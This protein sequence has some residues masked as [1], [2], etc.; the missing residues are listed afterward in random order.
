MSVL[1][2]TTNTIAGIHTFTTLGNG[3]MG[4]LSNLNTRS[5]HSLVRYQQSNVSIT[6]F[7]NVSENITVSKTLFASNIQVLGDYVTLNTIT[8]NTEQM[9]IEN[10]G[11]G[12][13][14]K[15]TQTGNNSIAEFYDKESG[16]ALY[17]GNNGN[18]GIGTNMPLT[19]LHIVGNLLINGYIFP[20]YKVHDGIVYDPSVCDGTSS[21]RAGIS[22]LQLYLDGYGT[23]SGMKYLKCN[24]FTIQQIYCDFDTPNG[25]WTVPIYNLGAYNISTL[26]L[27]KIFFV[28][29]GIPNAGR[30][31]G[32][33]KDAWMSVKRTITAINDP[34]YAY[35]GSRNGG[36]ILTMPFYRPQVTVNSYIYDWVEVCSGN[37]LREIPNNVVGDQMDQGGTQI[38]G[39][40]WSWNDAS[41]TNSWRD[42]NYSNYPDPEDWAWA[43][44]NSTTYP[45]IP[46][47]ICGIF[48]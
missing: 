6:G 12:P 28:I 40:W 37:L 22:A 10:A 18:V 15:V 48:K 32:N 43:D 20:K 25:P 9:V 34:S 14:L 47:R 39:G 11:T 7:L 17:V 3:S 21:A 13:A 8:S 41:V 46:F 2:A 27:F 38:F 33:T 36:P 16:V 42:G 44:Y 5:T 23:T 30:G 29:Q 24:G 31:A 35:T 45:N 19:S 26:A 1:Y 4:S